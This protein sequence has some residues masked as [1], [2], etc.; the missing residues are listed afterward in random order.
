M[1]A[2]VRKNYEEIAEEFGATREGLH[3]PELE[4]LT[5]LVKNGD[6]VLD[7][8]CGSGRL[9][10]YLKNKKIEYLGVDNSQ[11]LLE[12]AQK[13]FPEFK[14]KIADVL[15]LDRLPEKNFDHIF[16]IAVLHHLPGRDAQTEA[17]RQM[18]EKL[19]PEGEIVVSVWNLWRTKYL[20]LILR[21]AILK[22]FG[23]NE[24]DFGDIIFNWNKGGKVS[25]RYYHAFTKRELKKIAGKAGLIIVNIYS[26]KD[27]GSNFYLIL[28]KA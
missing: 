22:M 4:K 18:K 21:S 10:K 23:R 20:T 9:L 12:I 24:A 15:E 6:S 3:W 13:E 2:L 7:A 8:G 17:L 27:N 11:G 25:P 5:S 28:K 1:L 16:S 26:T 14:F 19:K